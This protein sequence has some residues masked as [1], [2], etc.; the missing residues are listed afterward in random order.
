MS[1]NKAELLRDVMSACAESIR[2]ECLDH[3]TTKTGILARL[4]SVLQDMDEALEFVKRAEEAEAHVAAL[5]T[6]APESPAGDGAPALREQA[7]LIELPVRHGRTQPKWWTAGDEEWTTDPNEAIR[8]ARS[9]D[10]ERTV[11]RDDIRGA[12]VTEHVWI[13]Q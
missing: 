10:A 8:Y 13:N 11:E 9:L 4:K 3:Y 5:G 1:G 7:W 2:E 12:I 6:P